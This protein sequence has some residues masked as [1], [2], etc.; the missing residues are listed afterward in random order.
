MPVIDVRTDDLVKLSGIEKDADWFASTIPMVGASFEGMEA[1]VMRFEFFPNRPDHYSVEGVARTLSF[2]HGGR[3][4]GRYEVKDGSVSLSVAASI[5]AVRPVIVCA[6]ARNVDMS[7]GA[8][9]SL[10]ELQEK[11]HL[12][13]GRRRKKVSIGLHNMSAVKPPFAY[14]AVGA[15]EV[16]FTPLGMDEYLTPG[17]IIVR[18]EK[19]REYGWIVGHGPYPLLT[20]ATGAVLSMPPIINGTVSVLDE[21]TRNLF[22]DV[23]GISRAACQGVLNILCSNLADRGASIESVTITQN[24]TSTASPDMSFRH[25]KT[26]SR[27]INAVTG[28][29]LDDEENAEYLRRMG[30]AADTA[31][32][33]IT[34]DVPPYR[35]DI[36]HEVDLAEDIAIAHG[37][38]T[39]GSSKPAYQTNGS[40][41]PFTGFSEML[42]EL[43]SGYGYVQCLT[44]MLASR[45]SNF[46]M[47]RME[48][49]EAVTLLNP[50]TEDTEIMRISLLPGLFRLL[51]ANKHNELPQRVFEIGHVQ[52]P[53]RRQFFA[54]LSTH[55]RATFSES[56]SLID[57][58]GRDLKLE[59]T[60]S[61][62]SDPRF[63]EGRQMRIG[64]GHEV[65]GHV[66]EIHPEIITNFNLFNPIVGLELDLTRIKML[67]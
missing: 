29:K 19:G 26:T 16:R 15:D 50:V 55:P 8:L 7:N 4:A 6:I 46:E 36:L 28:L 44:F 12:T 3:R 66:G 10:I 45:K 47:M 23:T 60:Y 30:Y 35:L 51:E 52:S 41:L 56:K 57:A 39:F 24:G 32:G 61:E 17:E 14:A 27:K 21:N 54:A 62:A 40:L 63:I 22:I 49:A 65:M 2:L 37:F 53:E 67:R 9:E 48:P 13:V 58:I 64:A 42:S 31:G 33:Q 18:H 20:D 43:M 34:A 25:M 59:L 11:L 38:E 1:G 5:E